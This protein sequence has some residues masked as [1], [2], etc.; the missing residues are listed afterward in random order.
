MGHL[1]LVVKQLFL[2]TDFMLSM[3]VVII[4]FLK[5]GS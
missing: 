1:T 4:T 2:M 3:S 5:L